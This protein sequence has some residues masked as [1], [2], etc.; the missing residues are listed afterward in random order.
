MRESEGRQALLLRVSD[1]LRPLADP[2]EIPEAAARILG[3]HLGVSR[4][5]Y[6]DIIDGAWAYIRRDYASG[7]PPLAG[8][9]PIEALG[10]AAAE[11][12]RRGEPFVLDDVESDPR[13][14]DAERRALIGAGSRAIL[15]VGLVRGGR[16]VASF[17]VHDSKPRAWTETD[18]YLVRE[19]AERTWEALERAQAAATLR[20]NI[21]ELTR[22]NRAMVA[23]ESRM[24]ELKREVNELLRRAGG[25]AK[26]SLDFE[27]GGDNDG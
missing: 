22:F 5:F 6:C 20:E 13:F 26:Y 11:A 14:S 19:T 21:D 8:R 12:L 3:E 1:A 24:I 4:A 25:A 17:G 18:L 9:I 23:R 27:A 7:V 16:W 15:G 10:A 2:L